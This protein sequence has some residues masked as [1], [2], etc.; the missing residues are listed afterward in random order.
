[1]STVS[2]TDRGGGVFAVSGDLTFT[3]IDKKI[4]KSLTFLTSANPLTLD[5]S[6]VGNT[7][8]AGLALVIEWIKYT[9]ER[10]IEL[11]LRKLP[12]QLLTLAKL[13]GLDQTCYF[14]ESDSN[15]KSQ[16]N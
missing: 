1:M 13:S 11:K 8:S 5:L 12:K 3:G 7:D 14:A 16:E 10:Q 4:I 9:R 2:V 6:Q 15:C